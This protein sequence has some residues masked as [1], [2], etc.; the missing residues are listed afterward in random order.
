MKEKL[1]DLEISEEAKSLIPTM[2]EYSTLKALCYGMTPAE[3]ASAL[4][5]TTQGVGQNLGSLISKWH[6]LQILAKAR[7]L[8]K[9]KPTVST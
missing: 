9:I 3:I 4:E 7:K 1:Q 6:A 5:T 2:Q 8:D